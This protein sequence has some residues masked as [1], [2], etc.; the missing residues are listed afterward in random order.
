MQEAAPAQYNA[1]AS[2]AQ[3]ILDNGGDVF[4]SMTD[5]KNGDSYWS[6]TESRDNVQQ[7]YYLRVGA[8][9]NST[10]A[11]RGTARYARCF[12]KVTYVK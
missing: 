5:D 1:R 9:D 12:R 4:N 3:L 11:K 2:F 8:L 10:M 7:A 6:S